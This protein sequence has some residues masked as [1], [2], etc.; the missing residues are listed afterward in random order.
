MEEIWKDVPGYEVFY[1]VS[2]TGKVLSTI[3]KHNNET[4]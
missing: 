2:N 3:K 4:T 1:K